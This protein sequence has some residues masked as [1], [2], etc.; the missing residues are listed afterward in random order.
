MI[1]IIQLNRDYFESHEDDK[2]VEIRRIF[3]FFQEINFNVM[4][5]TATESKVLHGIRKPW[6]VV[7][8]KIESTLHKQVYESHQTTK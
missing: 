4:K 1:A 7:A 8:K 5:G 6:S 2:I 3:H